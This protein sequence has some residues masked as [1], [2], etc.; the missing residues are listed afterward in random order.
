MSSDPTFGT[1]VRKHRTDAELTQDQ[2][3]TLA[4]IGQGTLSGYETDFR[5]PTL[6]NAVRLA[7]ALNISL[8]E[9]AAP[10]APRP[11]GR[12]RPQLTVAELE[13]AS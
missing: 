10:F 12:R 4:G 7:C 11:S 13:R 5:E 2:L 3:A 9:L 6:R 1:L 8:D